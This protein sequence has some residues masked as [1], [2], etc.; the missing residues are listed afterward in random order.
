MIKLEYLK[1]KNVLDDMRY[2]V[3]KYI[4]GNDGPLQAL[5]KELF[6]SDCISPEYIREKIDIL[7]SILDELNRELSFI[8]SES[9]KNESDDADS[10]D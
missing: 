8:E 6:K 1:K 2:T 4:P 10:D 7:H 5:K 3:D 9:R